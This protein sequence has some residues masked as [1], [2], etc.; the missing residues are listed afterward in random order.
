MNATILVLCLSLGQADPAH[1]LYFGAGSLAGWEGKGFRV[2]AEP[3]RGSR[4][5]FAVTSSDADTPGR[6]ARL[7]RTLAVPAGAVYLRCRAHVTASGPKTDVLLLA[8]D[9]PIAKQVHAADGWRSATTVLP[10][11]DGQS[12]EYSWIV[13][14]YA[15]KTLRLVL[16]DDDARPGC[17]LHCSGFRFLTR[18]DAEA[19][20]FSQLMVRLQKQHDLS[21]MTRYDTAHF[22]ALSNAEEEFSK[23][24]LQNCEMLYRRFFDHF[25]QKGF[26]AR[27]PATKL[28]VAIF[29]TEAG[30]QAYLHPHEVRGPQGIYDTHSNRLVIFDYREN[31]QFL[32]SRQKAEQM[33]KRV[34]L[35]VNRDQFLDTVNRQA[36]EWATDANISLIV[37]ETAHQLSFN[38]GLFNRQGDTPFWIVEGLACYCEPT[39]DARWLGIGVPN[40]DRLRSLARADYR[41]IPLRTLITGD[42]WKAGSQQ[43]TLW[44]YAQSWALFHLLMEEKPQA[45]RN[46]L[47]LIYPRR[48]PDHR[49]TDFRQAFGADLGALEKR[50]AEYVRQMVARH[51]A[52]RQ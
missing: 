40:P 1:N 36:R 4:K 30:F 6:T 26:A 42:G 19:L 31:P 45:L 41:F 44:F 50:L 32:A 13:S 48:T 52:L 24:R 29:D 28:M 35:Q 46:Y 10:A 37:H 27:E 7:E 9:Q 39:Q 20:E 14:A 33:S 8:G 25:R 22:T 49:L 16:V 3:A 23:A 47:K 51:A 38:C 2:E 11:R 15:G 17:H 12:Q 18:G 34:R 21:P 43:A 5:R